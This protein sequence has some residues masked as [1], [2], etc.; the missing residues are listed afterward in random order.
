ME[1]GSVTVDREQVQE[2]LLN[3]AWMGTP[4]TR[5]RE[6]ECIVSQGEWQHLS[7]REEQL[8]AQASGDETHLEADVHGHA[9]SALYEC[10]DGPHLPTCPHHKGDPAQAGGTGGGHG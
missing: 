3:Y 7:A 9:L 5:A 6:V 2:W 10:H 1:R 4:D 8:R